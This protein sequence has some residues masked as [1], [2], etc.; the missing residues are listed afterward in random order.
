MLAYLVGVS[1]NYNLQT[2]RV[3]SRTGKMKH[4]LD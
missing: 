3:V 4:E 1:I 2:Y